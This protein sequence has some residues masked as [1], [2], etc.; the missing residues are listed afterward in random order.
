VNQ[1]VFPYPINVL[2][3]RIERSL[4][5]NYRTSRHGDTDRRANDPDLYTKLIPEIQPLQSLVFG[6]LI[7]MAVVL[8]SFVSPLAAQDSD[9]E[10]PTPIVGYR[11][12]GEDVVGPYTIQVQV[13]PVTPRPGI[14]R[15][16]VRVR[17]IE[18]GEDVTDA[19]V[20][21]FATPSEKGEKQYSPALNSPFDKVFYL[22]QLEIEHSGVWAIDVEVESEL[23]NGAT[24]MS[25]LVADRNRSAE[26]GAA[27]QALFALVTLS[28]IVGVSWVWYSSKKALKRRDRKS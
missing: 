2:C 11:I 26:S 28:F 14:S 22:A 20:R 7:G 1:E 15:F 6:A 17:D 3:V 9:T 16:A 19:I 5:T 8:T 25:I 12:I 13:S 27:G 10:D 24:V 18:S 23:G 21:I 4:F